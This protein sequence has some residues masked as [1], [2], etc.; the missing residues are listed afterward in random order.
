MHLDFWNNPIVV[1]AFRVRY[2]R[3][4]FTSTLAPYL[5]TLAAIGV[6][7][8]YYQ[9][10]IHYPWAR[11]YYP[12]L[13]GLQFLLSGVMASTATA[14]S[15]RSEVATRTLDFQRIATLS[16]R[17]ILL[18]KL[19]GEPAIAYW[20][21]IST[22]PLAGWCVLAGGVDLIV[23]LLMYVN[24]ATTILLCGA[25]GLIGRTEP[26]AS[27]AV[28]AV[29][30]IYALLTPIPLFVGIV[31]QNPWIIEIPLFGVDVP[32]LLLLPLV[33][34]LLAYLCFR[35]MERQFITPLNP[36]LSKPM[37]YAILAAV[38]LMSAGLLFN[39]NNAGSLD[40]DMGVIFCLVH[41]F[42]SAFMILGMTA[43]RETLHTW[44]WRFRRRRPLLLD[45]WLGDRSENILALATFAV[46]GFVDLAVFVVFPGVWSLKGFPSFWRALPT[47]IAATTVTGVLILAFG[48]IH[49]WILLMGGRVGSAITFVLATGAMFIPLAGGFSKQTQWLMSFSPVLH[50][51][52]WLNQADP[53]PPVFSYL[54]LVLIYLLVFMVSWYLLRGRMRKLEAWVDFK[55]RTMGALPSVLRGKG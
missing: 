29:V 33:Q 40:S 55:L 16:P 11:I 39:L 42:A 13:M 41:L 31:R 22:F 37:A 2:R 27:G 18:G 23:M 20:M 1:S 26:P 24:L 52:H 44:V 35:I 7:L 15:M 36:L 4:G 47:L 19:L 32:Y 50:F 48:T 54:V 34:L 17:Q 12:I 30:S 53:D 3:G 43:W 46:I 14:T 25:A 45:L 49:Q 28:G 9:D 38:D 8:E 5:V 10:K 21:A 6:G 51:A